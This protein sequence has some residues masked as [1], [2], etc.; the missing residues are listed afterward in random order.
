MP[1]PDPMTCLHS[2]R[3]SLLISKCT[4]TSAPC[5]QLESSASLI[6]IIS[7]FLGIQLWVAGDSPL[8]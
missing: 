2:Q 3:I 4:N 1:T 5:R 6:S 7:Q 8:F